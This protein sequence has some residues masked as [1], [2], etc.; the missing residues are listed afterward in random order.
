MSHTR[1]IKINDTPIIAESISYQ[2]N[3]EKKPLYAINYSIPFDYVPSATKGTLNVVYF[4]EINN[5][6]N[7][8]IVSNLKNTYLTGNPAVVINV[9][10]VIITGYLSRWSFSVSPMLS[11]KA[12]ATYELF[13]DLTGNFTEQ[14]NTD[15][16]NYNQTNG[17]GIGNYISSS[18]YSQG[19]KVPNVDILQCDYNFEANVVPLYKIGNPY[20]IQ[21]YVSDATET[22]TT[23][24]E[25]QFNNQF[26]G[27]DLI[28][29]LGVDTLRIG[30]ISNFWGATLNEISFPV[31]G[32]KN[33]INKVDININSLVLF[34]TTFTQ[35][36]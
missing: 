1:N 9:S 19:S 2:Q 24:S 25:G 12:Q 30:S 17:S 32:M 18:F 35:S 23:I 33:N 36:Y 3:T 5:E 21:V 34:N 13:N 15:Y 14:N 20:P 26:S 22:L 16:L 6:P 29:F 27:H 8:T 28:S 7:Y 11:I 4:S 10:D 31:D